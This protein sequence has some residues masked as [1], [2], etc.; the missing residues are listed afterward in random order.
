MRS[1]GIDTAFEL[2]PGTVI[3][4]VGPFHQYFVCMTWA[5]QFNFGIPTFFTMNG[6]GDAVFLAGDSNLFQVR[7]RPA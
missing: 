7:D 5:L 4:C 3:P 1:V 6:P 2:D